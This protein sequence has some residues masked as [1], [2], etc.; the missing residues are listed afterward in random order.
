M[1]FHRAPRYRRGQVI[2]AKDLTST[3]RGTEQTITVE[4]PL[5]ASRVG[6]AWCI[7]LASGTGLALTVGV[8]AGTISAR[9]SLTAGSGQVTPLSFVPPT[10]TASG[11]NVLAY[12]ITTAIAAGKWVILAR[13][14]G[15]W[16]IIAVV[17]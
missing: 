9:S 16:F 7:R 5:E 1:F 6:Q 4:P 13:I 11:A 10:F 8:T 12:N 2:R 17:C 3:S 14:Y 15:V